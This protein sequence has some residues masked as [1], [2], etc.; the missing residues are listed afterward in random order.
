MQLFDRGW[1]MMDEREFLDKMA[2]TYRTFTSPISRWGIDSYMRMYRENLK[3]QPGN[4]ALELGGGDGYST[5]CLSELVDR[6]DVVDGSK[7]MLEKNGHGA[8]PKKE[9]NFYLLTI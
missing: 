2:E 3:L 6:L 9:C 7:R 4:R 1:M 8:I 5:E